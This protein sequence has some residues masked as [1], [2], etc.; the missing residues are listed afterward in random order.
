MVKNTVIVAVM[1]WLG[2]AMPAQAA[3]TADAVIQTATDAMIS[4]LT[5]DKAVIASKPAHVETIVRDVVLPHVDVDAVARRVMAKHWKGATVEQQQRFTSEFQSYLIRFYANAF[6]NYDG[7]KIRFVGTAELDDRG[8]ATVKTEIVR[9][10]GAPIPV[11]YRMAPAGDSWKMYDVVIEGI[12]LVQ[13]KRDEFG[14]LMTSKGV[15]KV[16]ADLASV[17]TSA[18][19]NAS[20]SN[21]P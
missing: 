6:A 5:A 12:S 19:N 20:A 16:I 10:T 18:S 2:W 14:P 3:Q 21:K 4:R 8:N 11:A 7:E 1:A 9:R 13:S 15:D 17:N